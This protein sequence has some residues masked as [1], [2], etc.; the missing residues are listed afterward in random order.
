MTRA[1]FVGAVVAITLVHLGLAAALPPAEDELY[2]WCWAQQLQLSYYDHPAMSAVV[3]RAATLLFGDTVF[4]VRFPAVVGSTLVM[5][6]L[7]RIM[8]A[9]LGLL[10]FLAVTPVGLYGSVLMTPDAPLMVFWTAYLVWLVKAHERLDADRLHLGTWIVGGLLLGLGGLSKYTM[11][12]A[13]PSAFAAFLLTGTWRRWLG[14]FVLHMVVAVVVASPILLYNAAHDF[15]PLLF[16]WRHA[17]HR[18]A[19]TVAHLPGYLFV[20]VML[21]GLLPFLVL[22]WAINQW[23]TLRTEPRLRVCL[24]MFVLPMIFFLAKAARG[25]IEANWPL[26][27]YL[28]GWPLAHHLLTTRPRLRWPTLGLGLAPAVVASVAIAVHLLQPLPGVPVEYDRGWRMAGQLELARRIAALAETVSERVVYAGSYQA[29][30]YLRFVG[31]DARQ[32][33]GQTRPSVFTFPPDPPAHQDALL[34]IGDTLL[35]PDQAAAFAPPEV[36]A[37]LPLEVRGTVV[38]RVGV[39]RYRRLQVG[40]AMP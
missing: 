26:A 17:M 30:S 9:G 4:A 36:I 38:A 8:P 14:G 33:P 39:Y 34:L 31:L 7:A 29:V 22:P 27:A 21:V 25:P 40:E 19:P 16:Q 5:L 10:A 3:I 11:A 37:L 13:V 2:Y 15:Q 6:L 20:Q 1:T 32:V 12:L 35:P 24:A 28:A 23:R 18:P